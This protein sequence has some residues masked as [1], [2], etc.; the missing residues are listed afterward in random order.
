MANRKKLLHVKSSV[1]GNTPSQEQLTYGEIAVNY[2]VDTPALYIKD[3]ANN[4]VEFGVTS[5]QFSQ[6]AQAT[7]Q[8]IEGVSGRVDTVSGTVEDNARVVSAALNYLNTNKL[9]VSAYTPTDLSNYYNKQE[10]EGKIVEATS[11]KVDTTTF[12]AHSGNT[13]MHI[14]AAERT[15]W[16][17]VSGKVD[18]TDLVYHSAYTDN[19]IIKNQVTADTKIDNIGLSTT[20][21]LL[22]D[23]ANVAIRSNA[24]NPFLGLRANGNNWYAQANGNYFYFGPTSSKA[25]RLDQNGNGVFQSGSVTATAFIKSGGTSTQFLKADGSVDTNAYITAASL[26]GYPDSAVYDSDDK[27]IYFKHNGTTL[28]PFTIDATDFIKDGMVDTVSVGQPTSGSHQGEDCLIITFNTD[29]GK[30]DIEIPL[31]DLF[32]PSNY[33]N[34]DEVDGL[35]SAKTDVSAFTAHTGDTAIHHTHSNKSALDNLTQTVI[36]NSHTHS[37]KSVLDGID[38]TKVSN[39]DAAYASAH[40]HSNKSVLDGITAAKVTSWDNVSAKTNQTDFVAHSGNTDMHVSSADRTLWNSVSGKQDELQYY[41]ENE[42]ISGKSLSAG[43]FVDNTS[44]EIFV[45]GIINDSGTDLISLKASNESDQA[46][47]FVTP[48]EV[49]LEALNSE[50]GSSYITVN[51]G[52]VGVG[53]EKMI[54]ISSNQ[55]VSVTTFDGTENTSSV[56]SLDTDKA[57]LLVKDGEEPKQSITLDVDSGVSVS[58]TS[59]T[60]NGKEV[61]TVDDIP[62][63]EIDSIPTSGSANVVSSSGLYETFSDLELAISA[64]LNDLNEKKLD[65]SAYTPG[66]IF[67]YY[68][69]NETVSGTSIYAGTFVGTQEGVLA[70]AITNDFGNNSIHLSNINLVNS[71]SC[72]LDINHDSVNLAYQDYNNSNSANISIYDTGNDGPV[73]AI[74]ADNVSVDTNNGIF[75]YNGVEVATVNSIPSIEFDAMPTEGSANA[76]HSSGI[77]AALDEIELVTAAG[78]NYLNDNKLDASAYTPT[79][80]SDYYTSSETDEAITQAI[81]G[82]ADI[83]SLTAYATTME[84]SGGSTQKIYLKNGNTVLSEISASDFIKDGMVDTV[85]VTSVTSGSGEV[86]VLQITFN[87]DAGKQPINI[88]LADLFDSSQYYT[89]EEIDESALVV[90]TALNDLASSASTLDDEI[91]EIYNTVSA[92]TDAIAELEVAIDVFSGH[93][94]DLSVDIDEANLDITTLSGDLRSL[95]GMIQTS[96]S[97]LNNKFNSLSGT[98]SGLSSGITSLSGYVSSNLYTLSGIVSTL[99][100]SVGNLSGNVSTL[101][102]NI[103]SLSAAILDDEY[104]I[105]TAINDLETK[106]LDIS[107]YTPSSETMF[108]VTYSA[109]A[110]LVSQS[111]LTKGSF[112][113][114]TDYATT[115]TQQNT[116]AASHVFD[117][118]VQALDDHTLSENAQAIQHSGDTY[119]SGCTLEAWEIKYCLS[120]DSSRF[121]W[122]DT[123][124]GKGVIYY[125]K[126]EYNNE[127][128]YDFKNILFTRQDANSNNIWCYTFSF[129]YD[130][131]TS[132][133]VDTSVLGNDGT[134]IGDGL[135]SG[136]RENSIKPYCGSTSET[137]PTYSIILNHIVFLSTET[138]NDGE[139][140]GCNSNTFGNNCYSNTFGNGCHANTFGDNCNSNTFGD[141]F[142]FNT[143]GNSCESNTFGNNC[144]YNTFGNECYGNTFGYSC[145]SNTFG[146]GCAN[147]FGH[148][149]CYNTF[150]GHCFA[151]TFGDGCEANTFGDHCISNTFGDGC[152][153]NTFGHG[154]SYIKFG[155]SSAVKNYYRYIIVDNG[156]Q[157]IYLNNTQTLSYSNCCQNIHIAQGVNNSNTYKTI[158]HTTVNDAFQTTYQNANSQIVNV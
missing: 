13:D 112:Y 120:N 82:K 135:I 109:L 155:T 115:T 97:T 111:G 149:F 51:N 63:I 36:D 71:K 17:T 21:N 10:T 52:E 79:D 18:E 46:E 136:V 32:D 47:L 100:G 148:D 113:R 114:I 16:N 101:S 72:S 108:E 4:I 48:Y 19:G 134:L 77:S 26:S 83:S 57:E 80:L 78:L 6:L 37:N 69:E 84:Y 73:V 24:T 96:A 122:A 132:A 147:T 68:H 138:F 145:Y 44:G 154:C 133:V 126:D 25:L 95:S 102:G 131:S 3:S 150:G 76:V 12:N 143:F 127:C 42:V 86:D 31:V 64:S 91:Q 30:E 106:K 34:K 8:A 99:S 128:P 107:A 20:T 104:V 53:A 130:D 55:L 66:D 35:L 81:S 56:L 157:Y 27:K 2:N 116:S 141:N 45:N 75:T 156:N 41:Y 85:T 119:F 7:I 94:D 103:A 139:Y 65:A 151:N 61:A 38:S 123:T 125:M 28:T 11:G 88:P 15:L 118:I 74:A 98:V 93:I 153:G 121:A 9:D 140:Y 22:G 67:E 89:K 59:F 54:E 152:F 92:N 14:T 146:D 110:A 33:Y 144:Y 158:T 124:N 70:N 142:S 49:Y 39:W 1:S 5:E 90:A 62:T 50:D 129:Y 105:A 137:P 43:T 117:V 60:Y 58:A 29:A 87:T 40:S 23:S